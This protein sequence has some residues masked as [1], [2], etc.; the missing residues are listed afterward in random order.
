[1]NVR[2]FGVIAAGALVL[3]GCGGEDPAPPALDGSDT[4]A[5]QP[6][7]TPPADSDGDAQAGAVDCS[8]LTS[9]DAATFIMYGQLLGQ[10]RSVSD[11]QAM[12]VTGY[13]PEAMGAVLTKLDGLEGVQGEATGTPDEA[14]AAFHTA[15]DTFAA[16]IAKGDA[17]TDADFAPIAELWPSN[18]DWIT[19]QAAISGAI[20]AACPDL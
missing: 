14:L 16:I 1:M 2:L 3:S 5:T 6:V 7:A 4:S 8:S 19:D 20:K 9:D 12:S 17:A 15:N 13:T 10:I 18:D 11:L